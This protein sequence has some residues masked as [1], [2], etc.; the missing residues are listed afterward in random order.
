MPEDAIPRHVR[1]S[2]ESSVL[3][4]GQVPSALGNL[5]LLHTLRHNISSINI[6]LRGLTSQ[7]DFTRSEKTFI[8]LEQRN[9]RLGNA[10]CSSMRSPQV[11]ELTSAQPQKC[12][13]SPSIG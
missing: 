3:R 13:P 8:L 7:V 12:S 2:M 11:W 5:L 10:K 4:G 1:S 9:Q 6:S